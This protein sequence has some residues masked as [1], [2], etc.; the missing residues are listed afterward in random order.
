MR[1]LLVPSP[2]PPRRGIFI[3]FE[4]GEAA[5]KTTQIGLLREHLLT[6]REV[7]EDLVLT[8][9]EPGGTELGTSIRGLLLHGGDVTPRAE[10]LMYAADRAHHIETVV[11]PHLARGGLVL[12]DRYLDSSIAYQGVGRDLKQDQIAALN[13]WA[14]DGLLPH[15]TILLDLPPDALS[16]RREAHSLDRLEREGREFHDAVRTEFLDLAQAEPERFVIVDASRT[17]QEVHQ[18][19]LAAIG[20]D[21]AQLDPTF[22]PDSTH[23][24]ADER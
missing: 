22:E 14:T 16:D 13:L 5:G 15:R 12:A 6:E 7:S 4:G 19:V 8:T 20:E 2:R 24:G 21:L 11:R 18:D 9:R 23:P 17:P 1:T 10:A 3:S